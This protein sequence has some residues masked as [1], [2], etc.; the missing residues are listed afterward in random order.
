MRPLVRASEFANDLV[1]HLRNLYHEEGKDT[2]FRVIQQALGVPREETPNGDDRLVE[3]RTPREERV[4]RAIQ[5]L[6]RE[7]GRA[8]AVGVLEE[9]LSELRGKHSTR[10]TDSR[11]AERRRIRLHRALDRLIQ[12]RR[13]SVR[14]TQSG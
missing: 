14:P 8:A 3:W 10:A 9:T 2:L 7:E 5:K 12:W 1:F 13:G 4:V 11:R 6:G